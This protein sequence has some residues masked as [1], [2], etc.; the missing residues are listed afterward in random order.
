MTTAKFGTLSAALKEGK[1]QIKCDF[2]FMPETDT[3][4]VA[5]ELPELMPSWK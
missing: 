2:L 4:V 3:D 1:Y 5:A